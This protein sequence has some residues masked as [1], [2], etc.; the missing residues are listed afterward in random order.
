ME[1]I[2]ISLNEVSDL[3]CDIRRI[4]ENLNDVLEYVRSEMKS[5]SNIWDSDGSDMIR[6]RFEYFSRKFSEEKDTIE[7]YAKF[8]DHT[9]AT[10]SSLES[11]ISK[12]ANGFE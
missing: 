5:L 4:N 8:L 3:A 6:Q 10:Y 9:V 12:N 11:T 2:K 1:Q 7:A